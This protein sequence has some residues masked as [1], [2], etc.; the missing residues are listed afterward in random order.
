M[1]VRVRTRFREN[2]VL[3]AEE[4]KQISEV[5]S[6]GEYEGGG[7]GAEGREG[8]KGDRETVKEG[9]EMERRR[10]EKVGGREDAWKCMFLKRTYEVRDR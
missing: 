10:E 2:D 4:V 8:V 7:E 6:F 9:G 3:H 1:F 5:I